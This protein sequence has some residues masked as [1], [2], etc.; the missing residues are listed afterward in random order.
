MLIGRREAVVDMFAGAL[1]NLAEYQCP[2]FDAYSDDR[3]AESQWDPRVKIDQ[4][5]S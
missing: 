3:E 1:P 4:D 2:D 5:G